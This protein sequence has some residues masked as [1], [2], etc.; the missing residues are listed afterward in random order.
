MKTK[1]TFRILLSDEE[2]AYLKQALDV[3]DTMTNNALRTMDGYIALTPK[4]LWV[5]NDF[6][7]KLYAKI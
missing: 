6:C 2:I 4:G 5:A 7:I 3:K 1:E